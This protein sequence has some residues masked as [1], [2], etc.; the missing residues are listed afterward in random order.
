MRLRTR[1][2]TLRLWTT[3][4]VRR[5]RELAMQGAALRSIAAELRRSEAAI[6]N[7]AM[8]H[9]ISLAALKAAT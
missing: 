6:R 1:R 3:Q 9:G 5:L 4:E 7:K 2:T 8:M